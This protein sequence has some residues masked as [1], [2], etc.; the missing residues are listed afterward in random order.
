MV[1]TAGG[2]RTNRRRPQL[3]DARAALP[4]EALTGINL[5]LSLNRPRAVTNRFIVQGGTT[6]FRI[7]TY[8]PARRLAVTAVIVLMAGGVT[9]QPPGI[10]SQSSE[11]E[12]T[13]F[14]NGRRLVRDSNGY[15]HAVWHS[16]P[17]LPA[18]P[19]GSGCDIFYAH[20]VVPSN[21]PPSMAAQP[22]AWSPPINMTSM[23]GNAD[24][25][26]PAVAIEY[27]AY[28]LQW[29]QT[30][31]IHV[32]WQ[33]IPA[34]GN[35]YEILHAT[36]PVSKPPGVVG[37]WPIAANLS[38]TPQ[39]DSLV[40]SVA[41]NQYGPNALSQH[42]HVLWQEEDVNNGGMLGLRPRTPGIAT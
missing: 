18:G 24:K 9:G 25:R 32:V 41:V 7:M 13:G 19:S 5:F 11:W 20:T 23:L 6:M 36:I 38:Q 34:F 3:P 17:V 37:P 26:Y 35:R 40:P 1:Q 8:C 27:D 30:N 4:P 33:A 29:T 12:A 31:Q 42:I 16:K 28:N 21:E 2:L 22:G 10:V 39:T 15:F 14:N